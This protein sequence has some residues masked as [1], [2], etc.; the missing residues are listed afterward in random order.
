MEDKKKVLIVNDEMLVGGV[1]RVLNNMLKDI[2]DLDCQIDILILHP[3]GEMLKDIPDN[4]HILD[5]TPFFETCDLSLG[6]AIK[7]ESTMTYLYAG[8]I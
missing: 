2:K 4:Y 8:S 1:A 6:D 5:S 3:Q 7:N